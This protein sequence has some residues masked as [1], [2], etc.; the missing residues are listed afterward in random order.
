RNV[1][2]SDGRMA[3]YNDTVL[4]EDASQEQRG[5]LVD[6]LLVLIVWSIMFFSFGPK[7]IQASF[8]YVPQL[9]TACFGGFIIIRRRLEGYRFVFPTETLLYALMGLW[10]LTGV[11]V[12]ERMTAFRAG[13][14]RHWKLG[15]L[16]LLS[17]WAAS[18]L[19][20]LKT[21][22]VGGIAGGLILLVLLPM[23][24]IG[25]YSNLSTGWDDRMTGATGNPNNLSRIAELAFAAMLFAAVTAKYGWGKALALLLALIPLW[26]AVKTGS[27]NAAVGVVTALVATYFLYVRPMW[28]GRALRKSVAVLL[29]AGVLLGGWC[30][31]MFYSPFEQRFESL[32]AFVFK[33]QTH[34]L[35]GS[36]RGR[37]FLGELH[38]TWDHPL[39]GV[40][41]GQDIFELSQ[42][43]HLPAMFIHSDLAGLGGVIGLPGL[44]LYYSIPLVLLLR[45]RRIVKH[46]LVTEAE[47]KAARFCMIFAVLFLARTVH[48]S[49]Y[50]NKAILIILGGLIGYS[51]QLWATLQ[52]AE[53]VEEYEWPA[54][55]G[56]VVPGA[57]W[58]VPRY[59]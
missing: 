35:L 52:N 46:P 17:I 6:L 49:I 14:F 16:L 55:D 5:G 59:S 9:F 38:M 50:Y 36:S 27:R 40:G 22:V 32:F 42:Y 53:A 39:F 51:H 25:N 15:V 23:V 41:L 44:L 28:K 7:D 10:A 30:Y 37:M 8:H 58:P 13:W 57:A 26:V 19:S 21:V 33:G 4:V 3:A 1:K 24:G 54:E 43:S 34:E 47:A 45:L 29:I 18:S 2:K 31:I 12:A 48:D 11:F 56:K 20:R